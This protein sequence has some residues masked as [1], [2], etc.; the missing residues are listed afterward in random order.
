MESLS[1]Y[2]PQSMGTT[3]RLAL[4]GQTVPMSSSSSGLLISQFLLAIVSEVSNL[5]MLGKFGMSPSDRTTL[6]IEPKQ[7][8]DDDP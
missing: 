8:D 3:I 1:E 6:A 4:G 2:W 5:G 7:A